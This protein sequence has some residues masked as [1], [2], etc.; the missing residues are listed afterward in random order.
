[1]T[2]EVLCLL[3]LLLPRRSWHRTHEHRTG[4]GNGDYFFAVQFFE[5]N[6]VVFFFVV[7]VVVLEVSD[8]ID[9]YWVMDV[10]S[11]AQKSD[12]VSSV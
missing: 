3:E 5:Y 6:Q 4:L 2:I 12:T 11:I 1:M 8:V 10:V 7:V 9:L